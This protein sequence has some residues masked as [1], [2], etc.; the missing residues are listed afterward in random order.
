[1]STNNT[2][3]CPHTILIHKSLHRV[4]QHRVRL[5][6]SI[7]VRDDF[8]PVDQLCEKSVFWFHDNHRTTAVSR[9]HWGLGDI[10]YKLW[11]P[12]SAI[13]GVI[14]PYGRTALCHSRKH[15][16][17]FERRREKKCF[18]PFRGQNRELVG[19]SGK[20]VISQL[21]TS[22]CFTSTSGEGFYTSGNNRAERD[23]IRFL[24]CCPC[25]P[26]ISTDHA[27]LYEALTLLMSF[28]LPHTYGP[29]GG[30]GVK[31]WPHLCLVYTLV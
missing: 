12:W 31:I 20:D 13:H 19:G 28:L 10:R 8:I 22:A 29:L 24:L 17:F 9:Y 4:L 6:I 1:M 14:P 27:G 23:E 7:L 16:I 11:E 30:G 21:N 3:F 5:F 2:C 25:V 15:Y 18:L 26:Y